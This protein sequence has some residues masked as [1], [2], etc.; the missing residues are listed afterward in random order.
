M[1]SYRSTWHARCV[2]ARLPAPVP[3]PDELAALVRERRVIPFVGSGF[4]AS[5]GYPTWG[6]LLKSVALKIDASITWDEL[7]RQANNNYLQIAEYLYLRSHR[8]MGPLRYIIGQALPTN[9]SP[10]TS[11]PHVELANLGAPQIYTT[12]YD[13]LIEDTFAALG[14]PYNKITLP[15]DVAVASSEVTQIVKYHGDLRHDETL[16]LTESS[17]YRRLDF[18]SPMDLKFRSDILGRSVLFMGYSFSDINIRV[19]WF[20]LMNMMKD[21]PQQDRRPSYIIRLES[22]Q[23]L[24][25]LD[26]SVGLRTIVLD[27]GGFA[28]TSELRADVVAAF[29]Y[30]LGLSAAVPGAG[31]IP[32]PAGARMFVSS[33]LL[34][35]VRRIADDRDNLRTRSRPVAA[36]TQQEVHEFVLRRV[37]E[38][39]AHEAS[40]LI[41]NV[42]EL[43]DLSGVADLVAKYVTLGRPID[44][45]LLYLICLALTREAGRAPLAAV[46]APWADIWAGELTDVQADRVLDQ[47]EQEVA[48]H[49]EFPFDVDVAYGADLAKRM[50]KGQLLAAENKSARARATRLLNRIS[51]VYPAAKD[52]APNPFGMPH[53][54]D[55]I[56][57]IVD[58]ATKA[59]E[60]D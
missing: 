12:N 38:A 53:P 39:L 60:E 33:Y 47:I 37:P 36:S 26:K 43:V 6:D 55:L 28:D 34:D 18:E 2:A 15:R 45:G 29:L 49:E 8:E 54:S 5:I 16:V 21:I 41:V 52:L 42:L 4:S 44:A 11:G 40:D 46:A 27:P 35:R 19:I 25:E 22:N 59:E 48:S 30:R 23:V 9:V 31:A 17:Y 51:V 50:T 3:I 14:L 10:V 7:L 56:I 1:Q 13:D 32:G 57:Q 58:R 24:E 20:K